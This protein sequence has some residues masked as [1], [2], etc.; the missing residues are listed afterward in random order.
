MIQLGR[1]TK[2]GPR[3]GLELTMTTSILFHHY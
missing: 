1:A 2:F 3:I